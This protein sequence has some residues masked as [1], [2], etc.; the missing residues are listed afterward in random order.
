MFSPHLK[1]YY[2]FSTEYT[3]GLILNKTQQS[4]SFE[5]LMYLGAKTLPCHLIAGF[6]GQAT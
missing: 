2:G 5:W 1:K 6:L 4:F 3:L